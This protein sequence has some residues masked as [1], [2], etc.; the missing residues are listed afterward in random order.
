LTC[1][2]DKEL[3]PP[4]CTSLHSNK[5]GSRWLPSSALWRACITARDNSLLFFDFLIFISM[6][7]VL[8]VSVVFEC[9]YMLEYIS[10]IQTTVTIPVAVWSKR[11]SAAARLLGLRVRIPLRSLVSVVCC[12]VEVFG[13]G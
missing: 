12:K 1:R 9:L 5:D 2:H 13:S 7:L 6:Y 3:R 4:H 10:V 11:G 8:H